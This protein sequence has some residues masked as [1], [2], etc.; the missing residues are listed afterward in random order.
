MYPRLRPSPSTARPDTPGTR[1]E[2]GSDDGDGIDATDDDDDDD[3][4]DDAR[5]SLAVSVTLQMAIVRSMVASSW[6]PAPPTHGE[7]RCGP[8]NVEKIAAVSGV[9]LGIQTIQ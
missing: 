3:D 1:A 8:G 4:G 5:E 6:S 9:T 2:G 7:E